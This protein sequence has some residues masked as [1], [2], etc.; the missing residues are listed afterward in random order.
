MSSSEVRYLSFLNQEPALV[1]NKTTAAT[2]D[3]AAV[4]KATAAE[5]QRIP[6]DADC[7]DKEAIDR[8]CPAQED[9]LP[10]NSEKETQAILRI[11]DKV[12]LLTPL[13]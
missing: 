13:S 11:G 1:R 7:E 10:N 5:R 3:W 2:S 6:R 8:A 4:M 12:H 9:A